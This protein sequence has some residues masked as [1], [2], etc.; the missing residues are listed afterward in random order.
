MNMRRSSRLSDRPKK[1]YT[2]ELFDDDDKTSIIKDQEEGAIDK[3]N[4]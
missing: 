3:I 1:L 4:F 2:E